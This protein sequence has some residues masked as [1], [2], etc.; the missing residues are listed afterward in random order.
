MKRVFA[1]RVG[2]ELVCDDPEKFKS[3]HM[4]MKVLN[5][6]SFR[7]VGQE[8]GITKEAVFKRFRLTIVNP[9]FRLISYDSTKDIKVLR[10]RWQSRKIDKITKNG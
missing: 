10:E 4:T 9:P 1:K 7:D 2:S 5:G 6:Q 3:I 8:Y